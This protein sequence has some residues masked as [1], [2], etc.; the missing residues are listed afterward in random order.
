MSSIALWSFHISLVIQTIL[1]THTAA[2]EVED[3]VFVKEE[4]GPG[5][6]EYAEED[7]AFHYSQ[8]SATAPVKAE[9]AEGISVWL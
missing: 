7:V 3:V 2:D 1:V 8:R 9:E 6:F 4:P 5:S